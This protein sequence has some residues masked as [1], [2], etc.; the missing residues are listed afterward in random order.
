MLK[1]MPFMFFIFLYKYACALSVYMCISSAWGIVEG[2]M[3]RRAIK[4]LDDAPAAG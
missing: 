4:R 1:F 3:V 2:K